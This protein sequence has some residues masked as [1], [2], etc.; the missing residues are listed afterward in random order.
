MLLVPPVLVKTRST[1]SRLARYYLGAPVSPDWMH[2][3]R[4]DVTGAGPRHPVIAASP[5]AGLL[6]GLLF[7]GRVTPWLASAP[8]AGR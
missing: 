7:P 4:R 8:P 2:R 1:V 5:G 6:P 3:T